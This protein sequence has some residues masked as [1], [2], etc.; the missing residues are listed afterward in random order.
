MQC[1]VVKYVIFVY[2]LFLGFM[3]SVLE[4]SKASS[5]NSQLVVTL[6]PSGAPKKSFATSAVIN[7]NF[8]SKHKNSKTCT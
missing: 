8:V 1:V 6:S 3:T 4:S 2:K 5:C 7:L